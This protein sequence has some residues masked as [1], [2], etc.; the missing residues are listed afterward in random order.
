[1]KPKFHLTCEN[2]TET[3][4]SNSVIRGQASWYII[5]ERYR[6]EVYIFHKHINIVFVG[7][8]V[9]RQNTVQSHIHP[10]C[11]LGGQTNLNLIITLSSRLRPFRFP[12]HLKYQKIRCRAKNNEYINISS[13]TICNHQAIHTVNP[14]DQSIYFHRPQ[15]WATQRIHEQPT[16]AT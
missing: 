12:N 5:K 8:Y 2:M 1:M 15:T 3:C 6:A 9:Q 4:H 7:E 14:L 13:S 11:W 10:L 16:R